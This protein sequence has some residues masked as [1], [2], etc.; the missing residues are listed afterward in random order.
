M[1]DPFYSVHC[2]A[3]VDESF[4][5]YRE[6]YLLGPQFCVGEKHVIAKVYPEAANAALAE[7]PDAEHEL[8]EP[9]REFL[10]WAEANTVVPT[11]KWKAL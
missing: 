4:V 11:Q 5:G 3:K 1:S 2:V 7:E 9:V 10:R 8:P 6:V